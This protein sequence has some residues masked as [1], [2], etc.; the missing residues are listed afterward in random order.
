MG[1]FGRAEGTPG[2]SGP[3]GDPIPLAAQ[4]RLTDFDTGELF[5]STL[6]VNEFALL[7]E[8][9][10]Q[11]IAQV[12]G[13]SVH[14]I[15]WQYLPPDA[16][17]AGSDLFCQMYSVSQAWGEARRTA[18]ARLRDEAQLVSADAVVGVRLR[19]GVHDWARHSVD[20]LVNGTAIRIPR[21][22]SESKPEPVLSD[23]SVQD[24]WKLRGGGWGP[25][26]LVAATA[27]FFVS[28]GS[29]TRWRR[30]LSAMRNQELIEFSD[31]FSAARRAVVADLRG[32]AA[33]AKA[34]GIVGVSFEYQLAPGKFVVAG[35]GRSATGLGTAPVTVGGVGPGTLAL[36]GGQLVQSRGTDKREGTVITMHAAGTA[37]RRESAVAR[38][39]PDPTLSL[40]GV[41]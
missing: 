30:R 26:G 17:W 2:D 6:S 28:Q 35:V 4:Q 12:L 34:G 11:P 18:F 36:G 8:L 9:G 25:A 3:P 10:P 21:A 5:S 20:F 27:V 1:F 24:Y 40:G 19:R 14:Q 37:I 31:A 7:T 15:G 32:Q 38:R 13:A 39:P 29:R 22:D 41:L 16:Q 23:L 33:A